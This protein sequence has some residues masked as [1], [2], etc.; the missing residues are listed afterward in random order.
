MSYRTDLQVKIL[1]IL[2]KELTSEEY[3]LVESVKI[4]HSLA[5]LDTYNMK[6]KAIQ[7]ATE[8]V[9]REER[10]AVRTEK[11]TEQTNL[12]EQL[13]VYLALPKGTLPHNDDFTLSVAKFYKTAGKV[14]DKQS[15]AI[16]KRYS[17]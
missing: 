6:A 12:V 7:A 5:E 9:L 11:A 17:K 1:D 10:E 13:E 3:V 2:R 8:T 14:S 4:G 16:L 15:A